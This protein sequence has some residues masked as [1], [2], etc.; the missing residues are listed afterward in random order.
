MKK[1]LLLVVDMQHDFIYG[2]LGTKEAQ[3]IVQNVIRKIKNFDGTVIYTRDTH[4]S[5]YLMTQ[6]GVN[7]PVKH[8][9]KYTPGWE[10]PNEI[11]DAG[12]SKVPEKYLLKIYDKLTF[13]SVEL[14][15]AIKHYIHLLKE[16]NCKEEVEL[17]IEIIGLCTDICVV[18]NALLL[19][20]IMPEVKISVDPS[21]CAGVT[22]ETHE[23]AL[24]T[25]EMCQISISNV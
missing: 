23:A 5:N 11:L 20:A 9:I 24:K 21:C 10:I 15:E 12:K 19:K 4:F 18:S 1:R 2:S 17:E 13:G 14:A 25:M 3:G 8:C 7:L 22:P 6:E 16:D